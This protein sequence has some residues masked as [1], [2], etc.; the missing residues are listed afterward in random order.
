MSENVI[1]YTGMGARSSGSH[2]PAQFKAAV[3]KLRLRCEP[4]CPTTQEGWI[5]W[6]GASVKKASLCKKVVKQNKEIASATKA[7]RKA[8]TK[9]EK[10]ILEQCEPILKSFENKLVATTSNAFALANCVAMKCTKASAKMVVAEKR[11]DKESTKG[12]KIWDG[13]GKK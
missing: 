1:C 12:S 11:S 6:T 2:N 13:K 10:C 4:S 5:E 9:F 8:R 7:E 3:E